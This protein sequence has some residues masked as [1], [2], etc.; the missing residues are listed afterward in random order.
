MAHFLTFELSYA[1][2]VV[3]P[4]IR[5]R[6]RSKLALTNFE[7]KLENCQVH[8]TG[9]LNSSFLIH[10][11]KGSSK[12]PLSHSLHSRFYLSIISLS[13][14]L[15]FFY[16]STFSIH[17]PFLSIYL[18]YPST[19][20]LHL[21]FILSAYISIYQSTFISVY[22]STYISFSHLSLSIF[23]FHSTF[24]CFPQSMFILYLYK[25]SV[26][27]DLIISVFLSKHQAKLFDLSSFSI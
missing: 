19:F 17:L 20:S 12:M 15:P 6:N 8:E 3:L 11:N 16:P 18:F 14:H 2:N 27:I 13:I 7:T 24:L 9:I 10:N 26:C 25:S 21:S 5:R 22:N 4:S 23:L 1:R